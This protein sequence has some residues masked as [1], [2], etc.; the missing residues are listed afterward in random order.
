M[1]DPALFVLAVITLLI[2]P[3]PTN[4]LLATAGAT[5][6]FRRSAHL[7]LGELAGYNISILV[8]GNVFDSQTSLGHVRIALSLVASAYLLFTAVRFWRTRLELQR[9]AVS[10]RQVFVTT[11]LNLKAL[12]FALLIVPMH[13]PYTGLYLASFSAIVVVVGSIWIAFGTFAG[14]VAGS[15]YLIVVPKAASVALIIFA[16]ALLGAALVR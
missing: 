9:A 6:G 3:G 4:T 10:L 5:G 8:L 16:A 2:T 1:E 11:L 15:R 14:R 7:L 12:V 13:T